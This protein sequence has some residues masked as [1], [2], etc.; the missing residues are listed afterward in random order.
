MKLYPSL[1]SLSFFHIKSVDIL[2]LKQKKKKE[3]RKREGKNTI[4]NVIS[5]FYVIVNAL[6]LGHPHFSPEFVVSSCACH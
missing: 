3:R 5:S 1:P 2:L 6:Y 4:Y